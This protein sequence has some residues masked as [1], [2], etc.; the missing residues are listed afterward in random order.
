MKGLRKPC[1]HAHASQRTQGHKVW[2]ENTLCPTLCPSLTNY[3][4]YFYY[5][6]GHKV[7][8]YKIKKL[9][10]NSREYF[11]AVITRSL[12]DFPSSCDLMSPAGC[13]RS[14][15]A[16][17][18]LGFWRHDTS[19]TQGRTCV[20]ARRVSVETAHKYPEYSKNRPFRFS[21]AGLTVIKSARLL[22]LQATN[23]LKSRGL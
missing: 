9:M 17:K 16:S 11:R 6:K 22:P 4:H 15:F 2:L 8:R 14:I 23:I 1:A 7:I 21:V 3:F 20:L 18:R 12:V 19:G 13:A 5:Y 10:N